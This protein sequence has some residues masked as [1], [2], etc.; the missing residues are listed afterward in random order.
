MN[1]ETKKKPR[2][3]IVDDEEVVRASLGGWFEDEGYD[4]ATS[5]SAKA[6]LL[7][8]QERQFDV[9]LTDIKMPGMDGLELQRQFTAIAP[10]M[11]VIIMTAYAS[12]DTAVAAL[13]AGAFDYITKPFDPEDLARLVEKAVSFKELAR[14]NRRLK[15]RI[16]GEDPLGRIIGADP[17]MVRLKDLIRTVG[18]TDSS[19]MIQGES[20]SGKELVA[21]A[22]HALSARRYLPLVTVNCGALPEGL[23]ESE[24]FG[25]EKGAFT[26]AHQRRKGKLELADGG[27]LFLDEVGEIPPKMQ[28]DLLRVLEEKTFHRLGGN[29]TV[30]SD[31]R[32]ITATNRNLEQMIE[33]G[34]F[35][36]DFFYRIN[37]VELR[38]PPLRERRSDIPPLAEAIRERL[39]ASMNKRFTG[40]APQALD[41]LTAQ[42]W[43]GNVRELENAVERAMVVG[44]PPWI[45]PEDLPFAPP[46][47]AVSGGEDEV[48]PLSLA[49]I[50]RQHIQRVLDETGWNISRAARALDI[51]RTTLYAKIRRYRLERGGVPFTDSEGTE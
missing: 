29:Q 17:A 34:A 51:D 14:E 38:I 10:D 25:H 7:L 23:L 3:L 32:L 12:V 5:A 48:A 39:A 28:V 50:E 40:F 4:V 27:T 36:R 37:V 44:H 35:R 19:V 31:F 20:G 26:G 13:K 16:D 33:E 8:I 1:E 47:T 45:A 43:P 9:C 49:D 24:L 6:S 22:L 15:E 30:G 11:A 42:D 18:P 46:R 41:L 2:L 21:R